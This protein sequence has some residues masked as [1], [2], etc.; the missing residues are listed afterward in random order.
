MVS[1]ATVAGAR[2]LVALCVA[3]G[4]RPHAAPAAGI[5]E[6]ITLYRDR[7]VVKQRVEVV[8]PAGTT[9][10]AIKI[11]AGVRPDDLAILDRGELTISALR[12]ASAIADAPPRGTDAAASAEPAGPAEPAEPAE[13]GELTELQPMPAVE[14]SE[15]APPPAP[16]E[17]PA[18]PAEIEIVVGAP[19][20][21]RFA[22]SLGYTTDRLPWQAAYT[23]TSTAARDRAVLRGA[24]AIRNA[25]GVAFRA[26][27]YVA[28]TELGAARQRATEELAGALRGAPP[29]AA[30]TA[31]R[32]LGVVALGDGETRV[33]LLAGDPP[34]TMRSVLVYDP[35]GTR[36]DHPGAAPIADPALGTD[37]A[38][39]T[40]VTESFE[41][42]RTGHTTAGLPAGPVRLLERRSDSSLAVLGESHLFGAAT[43]VADVDTVAVGTADGVTGRRER[44]DWTKDNDQRRFSE[45]FL[46]TIDNARPRPIDIVIREHLY[47]GQNWT[48][49]YQSAVAAKEGPQQISLRTR[50]P[51]N[52]SAKVLYVV[53]YTW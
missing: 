4:A 49:A 10:I 19:R 3:C 2:C 46:L 28:D 24:V 22:L 50:V 14:P 25:T 41:I 43:R 34:R 38:G 8:V 35:I 39:A 31:L 37:A 29:D 51:A 18:A 6:T 33:E 42:D 36:L 9:A 20:A 53:V 13:P 32:D 1:R 26:H 23:M 40:R 21:G 17:L 15:S 12:I 7:A 48:L 27:T 47:R 45:E 30:P 16:R 52:G 11:A 44:R 5:V